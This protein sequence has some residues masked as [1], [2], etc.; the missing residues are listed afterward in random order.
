M[1]VLRNG[2]TIDEAGRQSLEAHLERQ[3]SYR[4]M[5]RSYGILEKPAVRWQSLDKR[6]GGGI[7][8]QLTVIDARFG[9][10]L[11]RD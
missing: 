3:R 1:T 11:S 2:P 10:V 9:D 6:L 7:L 8:S 4:V 5:E